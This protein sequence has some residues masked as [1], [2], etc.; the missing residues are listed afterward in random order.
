[1]K[2]RLVVST[3]GDGARDVVA[4]GEPDATVGELAAALA[5]LTDDTVT[6]S[7]RTHGGDVVLP[8]AQRLG[9]DLLAQGSF[10]RVVPVGPDAALAVV[11]EIR[12]ETRDR[13]ARA[14]PLHPGAIRLGSASPN[15]VVI[16]DPKVA[17][18]HLRVF[19]G[20][21]IELTAL[22]AAAAVRVDGDEVTS[23]RVVGIA[24]VRIGDTELTITD[25]RAVGPLATGPR[26]V[27]RPIELSVVP[28]VAE[29]AAAVAQRVTVDPGSAWRRRRGRAGFGM[30]RLGHTAPAGADGPSASAPVAVSVVHGGGLGIV[31]SESEVAEAVRTLLTQLVGEH[32][33]EDIALGAMLTPALADEFDW[34]KWSPHTWAESAVLDATRR[35][36]AA[37]SECDD[38]LAALERQIASDD[39]EGDVVLLVSGGAFVDVRRLIR[40]ATEG[41][42]HGI[43]V[44]WTADSLDTLPGLCSTVV[45]AAQ[46]RVVRIDDETEQAFVFEGVSRERAAAAAL[47]IAS[48]RDAGTSRRTVAP[49][50]SVDLVD[51]GDRDLFEWPE[52]MTG[53]WSETAAEPASRW[54]HRETRAVLG[55]TGDGPAALSLPRGLTI[56]S[57]DV[58]SGKSELFRTWL[59]SLAATYSPERLGILLIDYRGGAAF[60]DV[61]RLPNVVGLV[62]ELDEHAAHRILRAVEAELRRREVEFRSGVRAAGHLVIVVEEAAELGSD[63]PSFLHDLMVLARRGRWTGISLLIGTA[64][65]ASLPPAFLRDADL[66]IGLR[67][68]DP[69]MSELVVGSR[70]T[71]EFLPSVPGRALAVYRSGYALEFQ[72]AYTGGTSLSSGRRV[73]VAATDFRFARDEVSARSDATLERNHDDNDLRRIVTVAQ[74]AAQVVPAARPPLVYSEPL[75]DLYTLPGVLR[76]IGSER[77]DGIVFGVIDEPES[78]HRP[79]VFRPDHHGGLDIRGQ[80]RSGRTTALTTLAVAAAMTWPALGVYVA[81]EHELAPLAGLLTVGEFVDVTD[82]E[83]HSAMWAKLDVIVRRRRAVGWPAGSDGDGDGDL[84]VLVLVDE[85]SLRSETPEEKNVIRF[86]AAVGVHVVRATPP[87]GRQLRTESVLHLGDDAKWESRGALKGLT[88]IP[89][90]RGEWNGRAVQVAVPGESATA[91]ALR[92]TVHTLAAAQSKNGV[93]RAATLDEL[94]LRRDV[95]L[96][97][98]VPDAPGDAPA[99]VLGRTETT[100][101]TV[102]IGTATNSHLLVYGAPRSGKTA[103]LRSLAHAITRSRPASA[104]K[105]FVVD[106]RGTLRDEVP[107]AH[108]G[109]HLHTAAEIRAG[110]QELAAFLHTRVPGTDVSPEQLRSRTWWKGAEAFV[111][112]D[113]LD[114]V[115]LDALRPLV[116][117]AAQSAD[118]GLHVFL[119]Q[120]VRGASRRAYDPLLSALADVQASALVLPGDE[121]NGPVYGKIRPKPGPP[122]RAQFFTSDE[123]LQVVTLAFSPPADTPAPAT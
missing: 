40:V 2:L 49:P 106:P 102:H 82:I 47:A 70:R 56:V 11:G 77:P 100:R 115:D 107:A 120:P 84:R 66:K 119:A 30:L 74:A 52:A 32:S 26:I 9:D 90:G 51:L 101:R 53:R 71:A 112:I 34:L 80:T 28:R 75:R 110:V 113:D 122:G 10:V 91:E 14:I 29:S 59:T 45:L 69:S 118:V 57:G 13:P 111:L 12:I 116:P 33:P 93:V 121:A 88:K 67:H 78:L 19:T 85:D 37:R 7:V 31:G 87:Y 3:D 117:L 48:L 68:A 36:A 27:L 94:L 89:A 1:M 103:A 23:A 62:T 5:P 109:A 61:D 35:L 17:A 42:A 98:D 60:G 65:P 95:L 24:R 18:H 15:D 25:G 76:A 8:A 92:E 96:L 39:S 83:Q 64:R 43:R 73:R 4:E 97:E 16:D 58:G 79:A 105:V 20:P 86:G 54:G 50:S 99:V 41:P 81:G 72:A 108:L 46:Q 104:A 123:G 21:R 114:L 38:L 22:D 44:I 63:H 6:L 55:A